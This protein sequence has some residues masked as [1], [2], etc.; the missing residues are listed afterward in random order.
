[1][2]IK[3]TGLKNYSINQFFLLEHN[4]N[5]LSKSF[6]FVL[7]KNP[8]FLFKFLRFLGLDVRNS[9]SLFESVSI[10]I[11]K[12]RKEGRTDIE[13]YSPGEFHVIIECKVGNNKISKQREQYIQSFDD[14]KYKILCILTQTNDYKIQ[15]CKDISVKNVGWI[16]IDNL[17]SDEI[18]QSDI[19]IQEFQNFL[20]GGY[21][22]REN[23]E[24]LIQDLGDP[25]ELKKYKEHN[26]YRR[27]KIFGSP[28]YFAP[29]Y[30]RSSGEIEGITNLSKIL[31]IISARPIEISDFIDNLRKFAENNENLVEKW[32]AGVRADKE[33]KGEMPYTYFFLDDPVHIH[34]PLLKDVTMEK[35]RGKNWIAGRISKNR[36]VTFEEF[37]RRMISQ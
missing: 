5:G 8:K 22:M 4:E 3:P 2:K 19:L 23:K 34:K 32:L 18:F 15:K 30:T 27:D 33:E 29:Y 36:C 28:L 31:G 21:N 24:I 17:I 35:G 11:E 16:D 14:A 13:I 12:K 37:I 1:M 26:V 20:R 10:D 9:P 25:F 7:S 6:A